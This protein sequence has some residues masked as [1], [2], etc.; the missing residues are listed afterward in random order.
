MSDRRFIA[1]LGVALIWPFFT[2][3]KDQAKPESPANVEILTPSQAFQRVGQTCTMELK[4]SMGGGMASG[5]A[6]LM[7]DAADG[8]VVWF[9]S[10][11]VRDFAA[12]GT[13]V[14]SF[15][16]GDV[17]RVTGTVAST[18]ATPELR[19]INVT[20]LNQIVVVKKKNGKSK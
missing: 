13:N 6:V 10:T 1:V 2:N 3:A 17:I 12:S 19:F 11:Q 16:V 4:V 5:D 20:N 9:Q 14:Q 7:G 18:N 8:A 15:W